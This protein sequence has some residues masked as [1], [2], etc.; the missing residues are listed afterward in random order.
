MEK[1][2]NIEHET[3]QAS[4]MFTFKGYQV[5]TSNIRLK[6]AGTFKIEIKDHG[7]TIKAGFASVEEAILYIN[8]LDGAV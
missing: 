8:Y 1:L 7:E 3:V 6:K 5:I 4:F 2:K